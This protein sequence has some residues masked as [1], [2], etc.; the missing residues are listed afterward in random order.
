MFTAADVVDS[1]DNCIYNPGCFF[2][3][4]GHGYF[5]TANSRLSLFADESRWAIVFEKSGY[6]NRARRIE[7]ELNYFGNCLHS[8]EPGGS[9]GQFFYNARRVELVSAEALNEVEIDFELIAPETREIQVRDTVV[10]LP[11]SPQRYAKW[12]PEAD[13]END[14]PVGF[15]QLGIYL[16]FE[17]EALCRA[18]DAEL[19]QC[20]PQDLPFLMHIQEWQHRYYYYLENGDH[21]ELLGDRPSS[22]ETYRMVAEVL[23]NRDPSR[24]RPTLPANNHWKF[25]P[26]AGTL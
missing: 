13:P 24:W 25:W 11:D 23:A 5:H 12:F 17:Y 2:M 3:E 15:D 9:H 16:A 18:T 14:D 20:I 4:L 7:L 10:A 1:M 21:R 8:L 6:A 26:D 19:R 22:Y